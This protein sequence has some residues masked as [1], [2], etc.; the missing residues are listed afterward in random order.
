M[1]HMTSYDHGAIVLV[2]FVFADATG[3]KQ[4]PALM[5][6]T[7][8]YHAGRRSFS[9]QPSRATSGD[10]CRR[11]R[12]RQTQGRLALRTRNARVQWPAIFREQLDIEELTGILI[13][14]QGQDGIRIVSDNLTVNNQDLTTRSS[15][16]AHE[17][18]RG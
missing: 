9:S 6:S 16:E 17:N 1:P 10:S 7:E 12:I 11:L 3:A 4:R 2:R 5:L 18:G 14:R 13:W 8:P 15:L